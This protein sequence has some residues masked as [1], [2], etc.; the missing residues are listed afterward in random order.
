MLAFFLL[1]PRGEPA[2]F[3]IPPRA[4]P[5]KCTNIAQ[6]EASFTHQFGRRKLSAIA[7][8]KSEAIEIP[9]IAIAHTCCAE[10]ATGSKIR[11]DV[12]FGALEKNRS[13]TVP[14]LKPR[15]LKSGRST[16]RDCYQSTQV[17]SS[18]CMSASLL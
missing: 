8:E 5:I 16:C 2:I 17:L 18:C 12:E 10:D 14:P 15:L 1:P 11:A 13:H 6:D 3:G 7:I 9:R 4:I